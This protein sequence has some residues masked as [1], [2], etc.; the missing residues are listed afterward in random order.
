MNYKC[1]TCGTDLERLN[2][3]CPTCL[4]K[5]EQEKKRIQEEYDSR[6]SK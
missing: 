6:I 3:D 1:G 5:E 4:A 2:D